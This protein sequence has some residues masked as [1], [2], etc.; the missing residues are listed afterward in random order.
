MNTGKI[1]S[2]CIKVAAAMIAMTFIS[3]VSVAQSTVSQNQDGFDSNLYEGNLKDTPE[4]D[5][6]VVQ[7]TVPKDFTQWFVITESPLPEYVEHDTLMYLFQNTYKDTGERF[8]YNILGNL[9]SPR[10]SRLFH[11]RESLPAFM[12]DAPL[13]YFVKNPTEFRFTDTK[14]PHLNIT[15]FS[16]GNSRNGD[17]H[18]KG[19]FAANFN[20]KVG[21]GFDL[22]YIYG[23]GRYSNQQTS[24]F[25]ARF[26]GYRHGDIYSFHFSF[27][28]DEIKIAENGGI[29]EDIYITNPEMKAEGKKEYDPEE[30]PVNMNNT[31]NH[32]GRNQF[33][34]AQSVNINRKYL[35]TDSIG[36]TI[37]SYT[38]L[39]ELGRIANTTEIGFLKREYICYENNS[40]FYPNNW[41]LNDSIDTFRNFYINNTL[42][43]NMNE[44]FSKWAVAGLRL[45]ASYELRSFTMA[46]TLS[47]G[48]ST[49][50]EH[51]V[52]EYDVSIGGAIE[53][54][55]GSNFNIGVSARTVLFG[56]HF[57]DFNVNGT[58]SVDFNLM[59]KPAGFVAR[60]EFA[61]ETPGYY[62]NHFHSQRHWWD[63]D[64]KKQIR[65][66]IEG[67][68][69]ID[70]LRTRIQA[71]VTNI[72][73]YA[74]LA[75][76]GVPA[77]GDIYSRDIRPCQY[78]GGIQV[79]DATL[80]QDFVL[81]PLHWDNRVTWQYSSNQ[82]VLPLPTLDA[83][84]NLYFKFK[85][86]KRLEMEIGA[87]ASW[88]TKYYAPDYSPTVGQFHVQNELSRIEIGNYPVI[89]VYV[90]CE[91]RSVRFYVMLSHVNSGMSIESSSGPFL[92][93]HYPI[94]PRMF[95]LGVSWTLF[96]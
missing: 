96:D 61:G 53:R 24:L 39:Q 80:S 2:I 55:T 1:S 30:I 37:V 41:L 59:Q 64:L 83:F 75:D 85:Y 60:A 91:I 5:S 25:D 35:Q 88:F 73:N 62:M 10:I 46:D 43:L 21:I 9:G 34:L 28:T 27:N 47:G 93:P 23:R 57:A 16:G 22:D 14:T 56:S 74:Y 6:T 13:S 38:K 4:R 7:R 76:F 20:K 92:A 51:R 81:G 69:H 12:F 45:F 19:Y 44:G 17:D 33:L 48:P 90:N 77:N 87:D 8:S 50:Y 70:K 63:V 66:R 3:T 68:I 89:D 36:D 72:N 58:A 67:E 71:G 42:S 82:D 15:Y 65:S 52:N 29:T 86:A 11:E 32:I 40:K 54:K 31:W 79:L 95:R 26:Y 18:I 94:N 84:S 49:E 78:D